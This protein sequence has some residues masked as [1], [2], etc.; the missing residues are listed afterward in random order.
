MPSGKKANMRLLRQ[1]VRAEQLVRNVW[2]SFTR[3]I[4]W[5]IMSFLSYSGMKLS[6]SVNCFLY[7]VETS[8]P[9]EDYE[10]DD[11]DLLPIFDVTGTWP[12]ID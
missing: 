9:K 5:S 12:V 8:G 11:F 6:I 1:P 3:R 7:S 2:K 4:G 10:I